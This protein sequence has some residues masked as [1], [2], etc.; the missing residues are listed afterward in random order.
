MSIRENRLCRLILLAPALLAGCGVV[1]SPMPPSLDIPQPVQDLRA[2]RK[3]DQVTLA[4]TLPVHTTDNVNVRHIGMSLICRTQDLPVGNCEH[5]AHELALSQLHLVVTQPERSEK[6]PAE[7]QATAVDTIDRATGDAD[8][9]GFFSYAVETQNEKGR[10]A[11]LSNQVKVPVAPT[12]DPPADLKA[13][14]TAQGVGLKW[15]TI[16]TPPQT[17]GLTHLY[18]I[19][20][21]DAGTKADAIAGEVPVEG[22]SEPKFVDGGF[23]WGGTYLYRITVVTVVKSDE[24]GTVQIEG[25]DSGSVQVKPVDVYPP[26]VPTGLQAVYSGVGQKP[27]IDLTWA[28]NSDADLAGYNVYRHEEGAA[29]TKLNSELLKTPAFRDATVA[30]GK[31]YFYSVS[32]VDVRGNESA[33]SQ[34]ASES[35]PQ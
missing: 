26:A 12:L 1:R 28:A 8:P 25:R 15:A 2:A 6:H 24:L 18:R 5:P 23:G 31:R 11:G 3:A 35:T 22:T 21:R 34:E 30:P 4:W 17:A 32:A 20:R 9:T 14:V 7:Q 19:Y 16:P 29:A 33:R 27:F 10:A 13:E